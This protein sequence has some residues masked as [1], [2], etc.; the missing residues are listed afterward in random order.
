MCYFLHT[1]TDEYIW[2]INPSNFPPTLPPSLPSSFKIA[3]KIPGNADSAQESVNA[4]GLEALQ[5]GKNVVRLKVGDPFLYGR[6][7]E[8]ALFYLKHGYTA[9]V[10]PGVCA[11]LAAPAIAGIPVTHRGA[12]NQVLISTGQGRGGTLP[13]LSPY[14]EGR[15]LVLLMA[16]GR[17]PHL[18]ADLHDYPQ[19]SP[20]AII[21]RASHPDER[22][23]RTTLANIAP[24]A[25]AAGVESPAVIVIGPVVDVLVREAAAE[26]AA[27]VA[28]DTAPLIG[29]V[30]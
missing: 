17:I 21:E 24:D 7:G 9:D 22:V 3:E 14:V 20:V 11:A 29:N 10:I 19:D 23:T 25:A 18:A 4:W 28:S 15:T 5:R 1:L 27:K 13:Q 2:F 6:G 8:E 30:L 12:A 26:V 16:V